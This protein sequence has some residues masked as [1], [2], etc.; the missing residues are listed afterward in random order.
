VSRLDPCFLSCADLHSDLKHV[1][2][3][4][5]A[6]IQ[7]LEAL[8]GYQPQSSVPHTWSG[9]VVHDHY[10]A[11][12]R[13]PQPVTH[14]LEVMRPSPEPEVRP[15]NDEFYNT[16]QQ[17]GMPAFEPSPGH[18][19]N[20]FRRSSS[21]S[22]SASFEGHG[23]GSKSSPLEPSIIEEG[24]NRGRQMVRNV[25]KESDADIQMGMSGMDLDAMFAGRRAEGTGGMRW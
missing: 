21:L 15:F 7:Q 19:S 13:F 6:R 24:D 9:G 10:N 23:S 25:R 11:T 8:L 16:F 12:E 4:Q 14:R 5:A 2:D 20:E 22:N 3:V 17:N 18:M 1:T